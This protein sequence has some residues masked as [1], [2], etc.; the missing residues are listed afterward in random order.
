M[1]DFK[2]LQ[3][4]AATGNVIA[5][6]P[7]TGIDY[8][9]TLNA[10]GTCTV[11]VPLDA[12]D[13]DTLAPGRSALVVTRDDEPD[14]GGILWT[15]SAD[16]AGGLLTLNASGW[17]SY[18]AARYLDAA[19][20]YDG[21]K[22]QALLLGDWIEYAN[23]H[24]GIG[25]DT[26]RLT[27]TGRIRAR[28]WGFSEFKN[29]ADAINELAD[30]DGGFDFRYE[31]FWA[32]AKR[33][34]VGNRLLKNARVSLTFPTL[35]HRLDADVSAVAFD[36][37]KLASEAVA[38]GADMGTGVKPYAIT[39]N[40]LEGPALTQVVTYADLKATAELIPKSA[41]LGAVG[42]QVIAIPTLDLYPGVYE[43][44]AFLPGAH[45]T[46]NVDSGYVRL[47]EE[48]VISERR[49][50]VDVNGTETAALSLASKEVFVS[51]DSG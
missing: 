11:G 7:V 40:W 13:P 51:G 39:S 24:G 45:G 20:G 19:G 50:S 9:E 32:D 38:F 14:W 5:T 41:A 17:H 18:Y 30:E 16:L 15:A 31:T 1:T 35:T 4:E 36:G 3:V 25:T 34:R 47:L 22:D 48:F 8:S 33:T 6:L 27:T 28:K 37:S 46:V 26:S 21:N 23:A 49:I 12:A 2:V 10:A 29:I 43:P 42:R 44:S